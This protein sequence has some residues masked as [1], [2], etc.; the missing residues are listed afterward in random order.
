MFSI[1]NPE[2]K[3]FDFDNFEMS[4][5]LVLFDFDN[6]APRACFVAKRQS[7]RHNTPSPR[8]NSQSSKNAQYAQLSWVPFC[9]I[10]AKDFEKLI[11]HSSSGSKRKLLDDSPKEIKL[12]KQVVPHDKKLQIRISTKIIFNPKSATKKQS[13]I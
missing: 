13:K 6:I 10:S 5:N 4:P 11:S 9:N 2:K 7:P 8:D 12:K 3:M 1:P